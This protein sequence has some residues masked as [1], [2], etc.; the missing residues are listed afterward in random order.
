MILEASKFISTMETGRTKAQQ[1][2]WYDSH[3]K[4]V[5]LETQENQCCRWS[6]KA[7]YLRIL[8][9]LVSPFFFVLFGVST[10]WGRPI[11]IIEDNLQYP[12]FIDLNVSFISQSW[13]IK[14]II[15][16]WLQSMWV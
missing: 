16:T 10:D 5:C 7:I 14:L 12:K 9:C 8:S 11:H 3:L 15:T 1:S 2:Q 4:A 13:P 6:L